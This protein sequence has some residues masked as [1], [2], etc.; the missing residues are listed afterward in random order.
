MK[1]AIVLLLFYYYYYDNLL[2]LHIFSII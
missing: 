2:Y 1:H